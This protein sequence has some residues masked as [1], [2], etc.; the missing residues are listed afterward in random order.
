MFQKIVFFEKYG[1]WG[2]KKEEKEETRNEKSQ[3][4]RQL[5]RKVRYMIPDDQQPVI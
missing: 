1:D 5:V 4:R 2:G 3:K